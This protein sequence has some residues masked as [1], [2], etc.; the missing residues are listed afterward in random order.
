MKR[1]ILL[2]VFI[3]FNII[4]FLGLH[5]KLI[6]FKAGYYF[7]LFWLLFIVFYLKAWIIK[8]EK[9]LLIL[10]LLVLFTGIYSSMLY[11]LFLEWE[12]TRAFND[13]NF[14]DI[15]NL[16]FHS[17]DALYIAVY[18]VFITFTIDVIYFAR[19]M[20]NVNR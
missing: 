8:F 7:P 17:E 6:Y 18:L 16:M 12:S 19:K 13:S 5:Y 14:T 9:I 2:L 3:I 10:H 4:F 1:I 15:S 20:R 11:Y